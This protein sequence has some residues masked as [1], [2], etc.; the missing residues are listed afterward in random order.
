M[1]VDILF[2]GG[3]VFTGTGSPVHGHAVGVRDGRIVALVPE[4]RAAS[5]VGADTRVIDLA[6]A[7]LAP[8]FQD[9]HIHPVGGGVELLQ[10][11]LTGATDAA[12]AVARV[13]AYALE[14]PDEPWVLGG[15]WSMHDFPG[16]SPVRG[17]LDAVVPDRP[18]LLMSRDHHSTWANS[19]AIRLAGI[20]ADTPDPSDGR[21]EREHDGRPA[22]TFHEGAGDLFAGVRPEIDDDLKYRG[23][24]RAQELLLS[25][26]VTGWQDAM[27][28][29]ESAATPDPTAAYL[30]AVEEGTLRG[31]VVGAQWWERSAGLEQ[32]DAMLRRRDAVAAVVDPR[33]LSLGTAKIMVD[34]VA[35]N[36]TAAML[37]PYRDAHGHATGNR[38]LSFLDPDVLRQAVAALDAAGMQVHFHALGDRAVREALDAVEAARAANGPTDGRHHLAHLQ[39]VAESDAA[40]FAPLDAAANLQALWAAHEAQLDELTL[41]FLE[42]GAEARQYP[43]GDLVRGGA[44]LAAGSDW[45]VSSADPLA[46]IHIAVTRIAPDAD[47]GTEPL[48]GVHQRLDLETAFAAYT[49]GSAWVNHRDH[50]TGHVREGYLANLV[51]V[52]P[53]PFDLPAAAIHTA[54]VASTWIEGEPVYVRGG[55]VRVAET[56]DAER[57][58]PRDHPSESAEPAAATAS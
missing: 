48:G 33:R 19:A 50:D 26:G 47:A 17:L 24:L 25:L 8:G 7:L 4:S 54:A 57:R 45:P 39:I 16:G 38:G 40:R 23:L 41:P 21:I 36:Q 58:T 2:T 56:S 22:G 13:L 44:R 15:G 30:R 49:S 31:H 11:D 51:V 14:H 35:E 27:V 6:G 28:A 3:P 29:V 5:L 42:D 9:A 53:N 18:V 43:F 10:C 46:A 34:G 52:E 20:D 32:V 55:E 1:T 37:A 12:D